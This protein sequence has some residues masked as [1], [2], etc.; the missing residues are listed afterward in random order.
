[1]TSFEHT[2]RGATILRK[3]VSREGLPMDQPHD[4]AFTAF[5]GKLTDLPEKPQEE[6]DE[7][8]TNLGAAV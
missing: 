7:H 4:K 1:M 6:V 3:L 5:L 8:E 2:K